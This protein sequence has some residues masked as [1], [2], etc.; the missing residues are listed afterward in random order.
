MILVTVWAVE[1]VGFQARGKINILLAMAVI[2]LLTRLFYNSSQ[3]IR[4]KS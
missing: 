2:A 1:Y 3:I 4:R